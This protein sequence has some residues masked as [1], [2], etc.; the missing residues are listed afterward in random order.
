MRLRVSRPSAFPALL[1]TSVLQSSACSPA[2]PAGAAGCAAGFLGSD[3]SPPEFQIIALQ[4]GDIISTVDDGGTVEMLLPPQGGRVIFVGVRATN[5]DGCGLQLTAALRDESNGEV[6]PDSRTIDL[7]VED[8]GWGASGTGA[9]STAISNFSNIPVC[10]NEWSAT[11]IYGNRYG[12]EVTVQDREGRELTHKI[13]VTP[14]CGQPANL[15]EC[16][17]I[18]KAGYVLGQSCDDAGS[19]DAG[20][21]A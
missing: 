1:L 11:N 15:A 19:D 16:L 17:C 10:P 13:V 21:G 12:L 4:A 20:D 8:G 14:E 5:I 7:L 18:C 2:P 6:R 9:V 3:A